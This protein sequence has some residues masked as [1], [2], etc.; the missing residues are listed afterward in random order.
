MNHPIMFFDWGSK[1][2]LVQAS[3]SYFSELLREENEFVNFYN[4]NNLK[5][6]ITVLISLL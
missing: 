5:I 2:K 4:L 6:V 1:T 3:F